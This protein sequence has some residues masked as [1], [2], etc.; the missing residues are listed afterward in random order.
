ML[1]LIDVLDLWKNNDLKH[2]KMK[3]EKRKSGKTE[4]WF[5]WFA[6]LL[7]L[8]FS[9]VIGV[10]STKFQKSNYKDLVSLNH[11]IN[12]VDSLLLMEIE[13]NK[14]SIKDSLFNI[15]NDY[16]N[17]LNKHQE[18]KYYEYDSL[19]RVDTLVVLNFGRI[20]DCPENITKKV[21]INKEDYKLLTGKEIEEKKIHPV[22][23][24]VE[25]PS[26]DGLKYYINPNKLFFTTT[27]SIELEIIDWPPIK[28]DPSE[29]I[30]IKEK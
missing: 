13:K 17:H 12:I 30:K 19:I 3:N 16:T 18:I 20:I 15:I 9:I 25:E 14:V 24:R 5:L 28:I 11:K 27:G 2:F 6:I 21:K 10:K 29:I 23:G 22:T 26:I 7:L 8:A 1:L 4:H